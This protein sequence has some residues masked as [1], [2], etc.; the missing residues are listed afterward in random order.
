VKPHY[1]EK[2]MAHAAPGRLHLIASKAGRDNSIAINQ[3]AELF[4]AKLKSGDAVEHK[5]SPQRNAWVHVATGEVELN[6]QKLTAGDAAA[7]SEETKLKLSA[8]KPSQVL[9]FDLN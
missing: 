8:N 7:V 1:G 5:L 2:D 6:G 3:D 4:L 9:L